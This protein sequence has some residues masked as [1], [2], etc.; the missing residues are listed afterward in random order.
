[1]W[2]YPALVTSSILLCLS[3]SNRS[4]K[5]R[6]VAILGGISALGITA[7]LLLAEKPILMGSETSWYKETP[8]KEL[9]T[10]GAMVFGMASKYLWDLIEL[11]R[12]KN[13]NLAPGK[14]KHALEF[15]AWDF[16]QPLLVAGIVFS[17][18]LA[19]QKE[20]NLTALL[21]SFQ[22]GFFWQTVLRTSKRAER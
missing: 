10:F 3:L 11:R 20:T 21:F 7:F 4:R 6:I 17:G 13:S 1:M 16:V 18:V 22:N 15:D 12:N 5:F 2:I 8:W 19:V 9:L 14:P